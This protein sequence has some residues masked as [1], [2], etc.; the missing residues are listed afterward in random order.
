MSCFLMATIPNLECGSY[1]LP[2]ST[3][4][5]P[6]VSHLTPAT[7]PTTG[8]GCVLSYEEILERNP[9]G[10]QAVNKDISGYQE[11]QVIVCI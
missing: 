4:S 3:M 9:K 2:K 1:K 8:C 10:L 11:E 7:S 6:S 5:I